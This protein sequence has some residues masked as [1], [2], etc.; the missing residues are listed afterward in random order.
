MLQAI[1]T[2]QKSLICALFVSSLNRFFGYFQ[3]ESKTP[4]KDLFSLYN[5]EEKVLKELH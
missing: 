4:S 5:K 2:R 3:I 1:S